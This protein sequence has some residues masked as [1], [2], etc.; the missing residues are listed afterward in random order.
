MFRKVNNRSSEFY[1]HINEI[2]RTGSYIYE[3]FVVTQGTDVKVYTVGDGYGH[4]E[5]RKSPVVDGRVK[6]DSN[7]REVRYPVMLNNKEKEMAKKIVNNFRQFICGFDILRVQGKSYCCD[8][9]GFSFVKNS[10]KYYEDASN[11]LQEY[12]LTTFYNLNQFN[13]LRSKFYTH[14]AKIPSTINIKSGPNL[15]VNSSNLLSSSILP[16]NPPNLNDPSVNSTSSS[17]YDNEE[18]RCVLAILRHSDRTPKQKIKF[19]IDNKDYLTFFEKNSEGSSHKDVKVKSQKGL[20][21]FLNITKSILKR[22]YEYYGP[23]KSHLKSLEKDSEYYTTSD[24]YSSF[25][26]KPLNNNSPPLSPLPSTSFSNLGYSFNSTSDLSKLSLKDEEIVQNEI[27]PQL[28]VEIRRKLIQVRDVLERWEISGI[29]RKLQMKPQKWEDVYE[30]VEIEEEIDEIVPVD[31]EGLKTDSENTNETNTKVVKKT[32]KKTV[33]KLVKEGRATELLIILKWGGDITSLG[34]T[35]AEELGQDFRDIFY[36][37][38]ESGGVLRLHSTFRHDLKIYASDEGRVMKTAAAFTKGL[39]ELEGQLTPI[40]ASLVTIEEK[41]HLML[42]RGG[43]FEIKKEMDKCKQHLN[44][45]QVDSVLTEDLIE[46]I[47]PNCSS[48][49]KEA[50]LKL[51]NPIKTFKR[52]HELIGNISRQLKVL[53]EENE[54]DYHQYTPNM[55]SVSLTA[56][57][58]A[59]LTRSNT[60]HDLSSISIDSTDIQGNRSR[61]N[62]N[63]GSLAADICS[64]G[65]ENEEEF[66]NINLDKEVEERKYDKKGNHLFSTL[67]IPSSTSISKPL[68]PLSKLNS[69]KSNLPI[70]LSREDLKP[71]IISSN[72][73]SEFPVQLPAQSSN[74]EPIAAPSPAPVST[75]HNLLIHETYGLMYD[76]WEK[77]FNDFYIKKTGLFDLTKIPDVFD[78]VRYDLIHNSS[79]KLSGMKELLNL[80]TICESSIVPQEYGI[81]RKDKRYIGSK[82]CGALIEKIRHDLLVAAQSTT[83]QLINNQINIDSS[84]SCS[85]APTSTAS[86][87]HNESNLESF[88]SLN[89]LS[90]PP[91]Y[92]DQS[93]T[94]FFN[95]STHSIT[96]VANDSNHDEFLYTLDPHH[97]EE[98]K[99]NSYQRVVRSRFYFTSESHLQTILNILRYPHPHSEAKLS[100]KARNKLKSFLNIDYLS[101]IIIRLFENK[102][103]PNK[104]TCEI[105]FSPGYMHNTEEVEDD[106]SKVSSSDDI[107]SQNNVEISK[108]ASSETQKDSINQDE[109]INNEIESVLGMKII[110]ESNEIKIIKDL[111]GGNELQFDSLENKHNNDTENPS[112]IIEDPNNITEDL[113]NITE[114][115]NNTTDENY[116][117]HKNRKKFKK[118]SYM[119]IEKKLDLNTLIKVFDDTIS[120]YKMKDKKEYM[121]KSKQLYDKFCCF[122]KKKTAIPNFV[123][124]PHESSECYCEKI[125][126]SE[127][128]WYECGCDDLD[129]DLSSEDSEDEVNKSRI[130]SKENSNKCEE[131][132]IHNPVDEKEKEV[133]LVSTE[134]KL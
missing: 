121:E 126:N 54:N 67:S 27:P 98:L 131:N 61:L 5:A 47:A 112:N 77:L 15:S 46:K 80:S 50:M 28:S 21:T 122:C 40:L 84:S 125:G 30:D 16:P 45:L 32:I 70:E 106:K 36:P 55:S 75:S 83:S 105:S 4:A 43:N 62:Q 22:D 124:R 118:N 100:Y 132:N 1:P 35:Q 85:S 23:K 9:N 34:R 11:I 102:S 114:D 69:F 97:A 89:P 119:I 72:S 78:M 59:P 51:G 8:V 49:L 87:S 76:R 82:M 57:N 115:P 109:E 94:D 13:H 86:S 129:D 96:S 133:S 56:L 60:P 53:Y 73:S 93:Q 24:N 12:I 71:P 2:R 48:T 99:I 68:S 113:N 123:P 92:S 111:D 58:G 81:D 95:S 130:V 25:K 134:E 18:L 39:L 64:A 65:I 3:E 117:Y 29:N 103:V 37:E 116:E 7:G 107:Q 63:F 52:I 26:S 90:I 41:N 33:K 91:S 66:C 88:S 44:L 101:Q 74:I 38:H 19:I 17:R 108:D 20:L 79:L 104:F 127:E 14:K 31:S 6:R 128:Y 120:I 110:E 42:D 10:K